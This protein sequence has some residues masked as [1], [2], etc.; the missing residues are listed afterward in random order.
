MDNTVVCK[1]RL[2]VERLRRGGT[3]KC[4]FVANYVLRLSATE[5]RQSVYI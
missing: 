5:F 3:F 4:E 1:F 2:T